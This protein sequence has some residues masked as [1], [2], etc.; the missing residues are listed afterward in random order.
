MQIEKNTFF[1]QKI[2]LKNIKVIIVYFIHVNFS[3][4]EE[5]ENKVKQKKIR[6]Q[7]YKGIF[8]VKI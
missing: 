1:Q 7:K 3:E 8:F 6:K 2:S 5:E 4:L